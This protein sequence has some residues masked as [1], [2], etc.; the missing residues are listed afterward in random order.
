MKQFFTATSARIRSRLLVVVI[1]LVVISLASAVVYLGVGLAAATQAAALSAAKTSN[2]P[3]KAAPSVAPSESVTPPSAEPTPTASPSTPTAPA[4]AQ[5]V[6]SKAVSPPTVKAPAAPAVPA[7]PPSPS[8]PSAAD[9]AQNDAIRRQLQAE[10]ANLVADLA[11]IASSL[12]TDQHWLTVANAYGDALRAAALNADIAA[13]N[14][15]QISSQNSLDQ[16]TASLATLPS[17]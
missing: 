13:L 16:V 10:K 6:P 7:S 1:G 2:I 3:A 15:R 14:A 9:I 8:G 5:K 4:P 17:Y 11:S 12:A